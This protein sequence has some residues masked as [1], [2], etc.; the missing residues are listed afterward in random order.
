MKPVSNGETTNNKGT[1]R[2][3][4]RL[5]TVSLRFK[6]LSDRHDICGDIRRVE[7]S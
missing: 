1:S 6:P 3:L 4:L 2:V 5:Y 7:I